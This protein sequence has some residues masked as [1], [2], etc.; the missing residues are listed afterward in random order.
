MELMAYKTILHEGTRFDVLE[1]QQA[2]FPGNL[3]A[4]VK[5]LYHK[6]IDVVPQVLELAIAPTNNADIVIVQE[7]QKVADIHLYVAI[8]FKVMYTIMVATNCYPLQC[9]CRECWSPPRVY[10][11]C[12]SLPLEQSLYLHYPQ[13]VVLSQNQIFCTCPTALL[14]V[15]T[16]S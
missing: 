14:M 2:S 4:V 10:G 7:Q 11:Y 15:W 1:Y 6:F 9:A 5:I 8:C 12:T 13:I 3:A 16:L